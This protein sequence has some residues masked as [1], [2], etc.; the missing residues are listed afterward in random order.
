MT[1]IFWVADVLAV[2]GLEEPIRAKTS[3]TQEIG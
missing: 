1:L 2:I 3:A